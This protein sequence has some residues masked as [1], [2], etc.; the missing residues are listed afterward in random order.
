MR[1]GLN[2]FLQTMSESRAH[3]FCQIKWTPSEIFYHLFPQES[4]RSVEVSRLV[5]QQVVGVVPA[6]AEVVLDHGFLYVH[7][8]HFSPGATA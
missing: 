8:F 6:S 4:Q 7:P 5:S 3:F 2:V 1:T